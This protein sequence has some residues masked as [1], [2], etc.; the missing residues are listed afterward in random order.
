MK[1]KRIKALTYLLPNHASRDSAGRVS[2]RGRGGRSKRYYRMIDWKRDKRDINAV[3]QGVEYDPNRTCNIALLRYK[4]GE[5][6]YIVHPQGLTAGDTVMAGLS[7]P[8]KPGNALPLSAIPV[9]IAVHNVELVV[10]NGAVLGRSAGNGL[11]IISKED[12]YVIVKLPSGELRKVPSGCYATIGEVDNEGN[13]HKIIGNAGRN[14]HRGRRPKN[15]G[16]VMS[17]RS[18]PHGGGEGRS[19]EGMNPKTP[20][21]KPARGVKT[22]NPNVASNALIIK[23]RK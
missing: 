3:V 8:I 17:P 23:R 19:G 21:G 9:G 10:G 22:R 1:Q 18:H 5:L 7:A 2:V 15:R 13:K 16:V 6:R 4:D 20:W 12:A 11:T 14:R